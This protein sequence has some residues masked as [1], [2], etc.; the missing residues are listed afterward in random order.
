MTIDEK[1]RLIL[2][3]KKSSAI[4]LL[5]GCSLFVGIGLWIAIQKDWIGYFCAGFFAMGILLA[6]VQLLPGSTYLEIT[7]DGL[8]FANMFRVTKI[9]WSDID[10]FFV[11]TL[12]PNGMAVHKLVGFNFVPSYDRSKIGRR[13]S[14]VVAG[15]E[16][17]L[18][19][20]YGKTAEE[21]AECL[22]RC[23]AQFHE[24]A[25]PEPHAKTPIVE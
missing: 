3:P 14:T 25:R 24:R 4:W 10:Q 21:L 13:I 9:V 23:L 22:N 16:G 7:E 19:N 12:K 5:L 2:R 6:I 1:P 18:P 15:C 8:S 11:V 17:A 20:T